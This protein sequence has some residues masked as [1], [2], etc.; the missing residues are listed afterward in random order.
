[1]GKSLP[2]W[3]ELPHMVFAGQVPG[4]PPGSLGTYCLG[5]AVP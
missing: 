2:L 5:V 4:G 1:M 3:A